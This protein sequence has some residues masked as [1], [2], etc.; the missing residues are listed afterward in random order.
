MRSCRSWLGVAVNR[1]E[2]VLERERCRRFPHY[3]IFDSGYL[4]TKDE[5]DQVDPV[6]RFPDE[7]YLRV[8]LDLLLVSGRIIEATGA[9]Y[10]LGAGIELSYLQ[11]LHE[12]GVLCLEKSRQIMATWTV[13]AYVLWRAKFVAHQLI[14]IQSKRED[15][16]ANLVFNRDPTVGRIS[17]MEFSLPAWLRSQDVLKRATYSQLLFPNGSRVWGIPEGG[18]VIRSNTP[19]LIVSDEAAFQPE[20][21]ASYA[22]AQPAINGGGQYVALSSAEPGDYADLLEVNGHPEAAA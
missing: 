7:P 22:A 16:A 4:R 10:A 8:L 3:L 18:D 14:L 20:F 13:C 21:G 11:A 15:D 5:H 1:A 6:K 17:F 2:Q 12:V 19:S 9:R